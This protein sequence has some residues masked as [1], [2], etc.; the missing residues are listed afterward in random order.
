MTT[1]I[2]ASARITTY[3]PVVPTTTFPAL[4]PIFDNADLALYVNG[5]P[6][7]F[8][9]SATYVEGVSTDATCIVASGVTGTVIVL[10][11]RD[12]R[13]TDQFGTGPLPTSDLNYAL[14]RLTIESQEAHRDIARSLKAPVGSEGMEL[15]APSP[16]LALAWDED[17]NLINAPV[18]AG[19]V[20]TAVDQ[21]RGYR[22]AAQGSATTATTQAGIAT[23][24]AGKTAADVVTTANNAA[25]SA[26]TGPKYTTEALGRAAVADGVSFLVQGSGDIAAYEYRRVNS[27]ASTLI[28][29]YIS[30]APVLG[31]AAN[32]DVTPPK[33]KYN[34]ALAVDGLLRNYVGGATAAFANGIDSGL[35]PVTEGNT[36]T[37][38][39][40]ASERGFF[41]HV[42]C[43]DAVGAYL[44]MDALM[45]T[46]PVIPGM[47]MT[48]SAPG[49]T[50]G[51]QV[52][53]FTIPVGSGIA[54]V[55]TGML[56]NYAAHSTADFNRIRNSV[57]LEI[58]ATATAFVPYTTLNTYT[59]KDPAVL[60]PAL[61][62]SITRLA[63]DLYLRGTYDATYDLIQKITLATG[64]AFSNDTINVQGARKALKTVTDNVIAWAT[65]TI[66]VAQGDDTAPLNYNGTYIAGDH[67]ANF[68]REVTATAH[69]KTVQD[70]GSEWNDGA[71][72]KWYLMRVVDNDKLWFLS[73]NTSV[74]PAWS[75]VSTLTGNLTHS[76]G[77]TN[78]G[79]I[80]VA[81]SVLTQLLPAT[82]SISKSVLLDSV[83]P[84]STDRSARARWVDIVEVTKVCN[85]AS[86]LAYVRS[87]V[88]GAV[89]PAFNHPSIAADVQRT[90]TYRYAENGSCCII[91]GILVLNPLILGYF[92]GTQAHPLTY[93]GKQLF[94]Y[95]PRMQTVTV[96]SN[97][98]DLSAQAN[99]GALADQINLLAAR[100]LD[101]NNPPDRMSQIVKT[102]G[103]AEYGLTIG[104]NP[105]RGLGQPGTRKNVINQ[106]GFISAIHKF[107]PYAVNVGP[108]AANS[109][110]EIEAFRAY[111][112]ASDAPLASV[113]TWYR[114]GANNIIV[115]AD[116]H[117][118]VTAYPLVL[119]ASF[120]GKSVSV[121]DKSASLSV[122]G[123]GV[124]T[125]GGVLVTVTGGYG[126]VVLMLKP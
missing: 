88:G 11:A 96:G 100:W 89:Q 5:E 10:G 98:Y 38:S 7:A 91:D 17:G 2:T 16:G 22:D 83:T 99:I 119:P 26:V 23:T 72:V 44:G 18:A 8:T 82:Q 43:Y 51:Y 41:P 6:A 103:V 84:L 30:A 35:M 111:H 67:G 74:Y 46:N 37:L 78:I 40:G 101:P 108:V 76:S 105:S 68:I 59:P 125:S 53:T 50:G 85:P 121:V 14:N 20:A 3:N 117:Q 24:N 86:V 31:M 1:P 116:F 55:A 123:N 33:N 32:F 81:S 95:V 115:I 29:T 92:G 57:Q 66:L 122:L 79:A 28:A 93:T 71:A 118:N 9:V 63:N 45:T 64:A 54:F 70:V 114:D 69:G 107:Y 120:V 109:Y 60:T 97:V 75:F 110:F 113:F 102:A 49:G 126:Y 52:L 62:I 15:P 34:P 90:V 58:G 19:D 87:Q 56:F 47:G 36:Y 12:P 39:Q 77:A 21:A 25:I 61:P 124:L 27:G 106:A 104:Y 4:F 65:G 73:Q 48:P 42:Y 112:V 13:R 94:A 80:T